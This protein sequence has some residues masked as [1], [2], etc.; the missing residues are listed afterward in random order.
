MRTIETLNE[1]ERPVVRR[2]RGSDGSSLRDRVVITATVIGVIAFVLVGLPYLKHDVPPE[3]RRVSVTGDIRS[4]PDRD[5]V[6]NW[7]HANCRDPHPREIR[8]WPARTL[9]EFYRQQLISAK[10]AAEDDPEFY[11]YVEQLEHDGPERVCRLKYRARNEV[12]A[13]VQF[14]QMFTLYNG[15]VRPIR[16]DSSGARAMRKYFPDD[17]GDP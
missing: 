4:D 16:N 5:A 2:R 14:D 9:D 11:D 8:W 12:G 17:G 10:E 6:R 3:G 15:R 7:L 13:A 1:A